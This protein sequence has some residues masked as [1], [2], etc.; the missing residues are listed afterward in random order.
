MG[1]ADQ[2]HVVLL[3]E[4]R[5]DVR[6]E[7]KADASVIFAPTGNIFVGVG[8]QQVAKQAA[9]GD[10]WKKVRIYIERPQRK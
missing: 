1:T 7:C 8:P 5:Y 4:A 3:E 2:I 6:T 10:L 9:V